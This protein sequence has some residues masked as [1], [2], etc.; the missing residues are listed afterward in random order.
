MEELEREVAMP[1][2]DLEHPTSFRSDSSPSN[3]TC[4]RRIVFDVTVCEKNDFSL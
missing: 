2:A 3:S 4:M 1:A